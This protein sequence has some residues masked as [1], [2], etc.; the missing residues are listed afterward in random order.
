MLDLL[1]DTPH[2]TQVVVFCNQDTLAHQLTGILNERNISSS[3]VYGD[4]D[5]AEREAVFDPF[6][7][8][9]RHVVVVSGRLAS[10]TDFL[11]QASLIVNYDLPSLCE[12]YIHR[13]GRS[14]SSGRNGGKA[15]AINFLTNKDELLKTEVEKFYNTRI[16]EMP[17]NI[18]EI[19]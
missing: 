16:M 14:S 11:Q 15:T 18:A 9:S 13:V 4:K 6:H 10:H 1:K 19:F 12:E 2:V 7:S 8:G 5:L 3:A 17:E